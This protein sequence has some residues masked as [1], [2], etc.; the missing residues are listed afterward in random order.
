M[1]FRLDCGGR[2]FGSFVTR[3]L[4]HRNV[5]PFQGALSPAVSGGS[6]GYLSPSIHLLSIS[7]GL[8]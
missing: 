4:S 1:L 6:Q 2:F 7:I 3:H 5:F 8:F